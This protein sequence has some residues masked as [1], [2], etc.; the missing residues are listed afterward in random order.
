MEQDEG[1]A[2]KEE[3]Q[4]AITAGAE[5]PDPVFKMLGMGLADK[6]AAHFQELKGTDKLP[7]L[8]FV[9]PTGRG[10]QLFKKDESWCFTSLV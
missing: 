1:L 2:L 8:D 3:I 7:V 10:M 9:I 4:N 5:F 6:G